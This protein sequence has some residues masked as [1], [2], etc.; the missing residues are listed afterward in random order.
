MTSHLNKKRFD[1]NLQH[2]LK[3]LSQPGTLYLPLTPIGKKYNSIFHTI[4][5]LHGKLF[6]HKGICISIEI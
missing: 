2:L 5:T 6:L 3:I 1:I 4:H